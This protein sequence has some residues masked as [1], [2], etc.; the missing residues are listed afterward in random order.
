MVINPTYSPCSATTR[1][2]E[3]STFLVLTST[4]DDLVNFIDELRRETDRGL[5]L[6]AAA[7]IDNRLAETIRSFLRPGDLAAKLIDA[8][9]APLG[10]LSARA[11][12][13]YALGLIDEYEHSEIAIIRK[14][15]NEFAHA[16]H[17]LTFENPRVKGLCSTL[18]TSSPEPA[19]VHTNEPR[20]RFMNAALAIVLRIYH[21]PDWASL[22]RRQSKLWPSDPY[23][24]HPDQTVRDEF[25]VPHVINVD[26][27]PHA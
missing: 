23:Q 10:T 26:A 21:R 8:G 12:L 3:W 7:L 9:N 24:L 4:A 15:R 16:R 27:N 2:L 5:P 6:V 14:V 19:L 22:E 11:D 25:G 13:C 17:G 18:Q 20:L 1:N